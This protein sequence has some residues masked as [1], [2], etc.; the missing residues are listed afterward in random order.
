LDRESCRIRHPGL[1]HELGEP[2][3]PGILV[4]ARDLGDLMIR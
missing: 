1:G 2:L 3:P 4:V